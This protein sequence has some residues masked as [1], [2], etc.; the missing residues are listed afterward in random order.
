MNC[1]R[2][3]S[4]AEDDYDV[5]SIEESG[6]CCACRDEIDEMDSETPFVLE[7]EWD[8]MDICGYYDD[9]GYR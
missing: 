7:D 2:C 9:R 6:L 5:E 4:P 1:K 3:D 8:P